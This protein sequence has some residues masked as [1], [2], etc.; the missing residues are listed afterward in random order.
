MERRQAQ[1]RRQRL[2]RDR[3]L[4][5]VERDVDHGGNGERAFVP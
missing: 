3:T 2:G 1:A 5:R 4:V